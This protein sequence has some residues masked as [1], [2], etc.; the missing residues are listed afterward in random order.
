MVKCIGLYDEV[1]LF[2]V[3]VYRKIETCDFDDEE[4]YEDY[5][6]IIDKIY[7]MKKEE[8]KPFFK[9]L[10]DFY[11]GRFF[12]DVCISMTELT[13]DEKYGRT[14]FKQNWDGHTNVK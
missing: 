6:D 10:C 13:E 2:R 5:E 11:S 7:S 3:N 8:I 14:M 4:L 9:N 12:E 1:Y